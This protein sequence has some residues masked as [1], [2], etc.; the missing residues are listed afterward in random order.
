MEVVKIE[1]MD[2]LRAKERLGKTSSEGV[3][4]RYTRIVISLTDARTDEAL[5]INGDYLAVAKMDGVASTTFFKLN[6]KNARAIYPSEIEKLYADFSKVFLTNAAE[7]GKELIIYVGGALSGEIKTATGK[8][9]LKDS[10]GSDIDPATEDSLSTIVSNQFD[11]SV[12]TM[13]LRFNGKPYSTPKTST[14][15]CQRF[16]GTNPKKIAD[17]IIRNTDA[18][19][20]VDIGLY[21]ATPATLR[22]ASFELGALAS[23]GFTQVDLYQLGIVSSVDGSHAVVQVIGVE[24]Y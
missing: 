7:A 6:H 13:M 15:A 16:N 12:D 10:S 2:I 5:H 11:A 22:A 1:W 9:G 4:E 19:N 3:K 14:N 23:I 18:A 21:N 24:S 17:I 8:T 20:A